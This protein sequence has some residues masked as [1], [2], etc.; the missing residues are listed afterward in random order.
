MLL[1]VALGECHVKNMV[2]DFDWLWREFFRMMK[3]YKY[4]H[5]S[6]YEGEENCHSQ[7]VMWLPDK[8]EAVKQRVDLWRPKKIREPLYKKDDVTNQ[9]GLL[10]ENISVLLIVRRHKELSVDTYWTFFFC[11]TFI[12]KKYI[13]KLSFNLDP[14]LI[15]CK[16]FMDEFWS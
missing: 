6:P 4:P 9:F 13:S 14:W 16:A 3:R 7:V 10:P 2:E 8:N 11:K 12:K 15:I 1:C 5:L